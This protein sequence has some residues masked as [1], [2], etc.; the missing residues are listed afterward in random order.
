MANQRRPEVRAADLR[1]LKY[2]KILNP[3]LDGLHQQATQRDRAGNRQ[4]FFDQYASLLLLYFFN[5]IV[6]GLRSIQQASQL[7]KVQKLLGCQR[8]SLGSLSEASH[9]FDAQALHPLIAELASQAI[10]IVVGKEAEALRGLTAVDGSLLPALSKM[11]WALWVDDQHRAAKMHIHFDVLKGVPVEATVTAGNSSETAQLRAT[12]QAGR[13]YVIDRG[14][15]DYQLFQDIIDAGSGFIG[16]L[17]SNAVSTVL[18]ER[19]LS[20]EAITA[21]VR[22][23]RVV[24]LGGP[25]SG[26]VLRQLLRLVEVHTTD[27]HGKAIVLLLVTNRLDLDAELVALGYRYRWAIEIYQ[28]HYTSSASCCQSRFAGYDS[29]CGVARIGPLGR[30]TPWEFNRRNP[31]SSHARSTPPPRADRK[32]RR[33]PRRAC[34]GPVCPLGSGRNSTIG[35]AR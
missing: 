5:P 15:A 30:A 7:D 12:L 17:K 29:G 27:E 20:A 24:Q 25:Q 18:E 34:S 10:P 28:A 26:A 33:L 14:Y 32:R 21:G 2:F 23:D 1:G 31:M 6:T 3:L 35:S 16:R 9:V 8:A 4:L 22:S 11:A 13:L 19:P